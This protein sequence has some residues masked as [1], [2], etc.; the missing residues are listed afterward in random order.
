MILTLWQTLP[1]FPLPFCWFLLIAFMV[2]PEYSERSTKQPSHSARTIFCLWNM[3]SRISTNRL[4]TRPKCLRNPS[5]LS[6]TP[7]GLQQQPT[8]FFCLCRG[9]GELP[10][11][12]LKSWRHHTQRTVSWWFGEA[13]NHWKSKLTL[14]C[15][16]SAPSIP[17]CLKDSL[18]TTGAKNPSQ[19]PHVLGFNPQ[20]HWYKMEG[21]LMAFDCTSNMNHLW[22]V[23]SK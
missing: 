11:H 7:F 16:H 19:K 4:L 17:F 5:P 23:P 20:Q 1:T 6:T 8:L 21:A 14:I 3:V 10:G 13:L 2:F 9:F 15:L 18:T 22:A 12:T